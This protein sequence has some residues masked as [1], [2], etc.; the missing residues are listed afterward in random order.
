MNRLHF[1][2]RAAWL[3]ALTEW[4]DSS[5]ARQ[6]KPEG[7]SMKVTRTELVDAA[8][9]ILE[10]D[11]RGASEYFLATLPAWVDRVVPPR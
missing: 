7:W 4:Q 5:W 10:V 1:E 8:A 9:M 6:G 3:H 2:T 11:V